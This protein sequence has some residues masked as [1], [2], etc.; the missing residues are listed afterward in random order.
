MSNEAQTYRISGFIRF[1]FLLG[2]ILFGAF[3]V[4]FILDNA[5]DVIDSC[6]PP[7]AL[8]FLG[9]FIWSLYTVRL[10]DRGISVTYFF[11]TVN[12]NW[13][14]ISDIHFKESGFIL[15]CNDGRRGMLINSQ[16]VGFIKIVE[17][18]KRRLPI[19]WNNKITYEFHASL[20]TFAVFAGIGLFGVAMLVWAISD[21]MDSSGNLLSD[22]ILAAIGLFCI[23]TPLIVPVKETFQEDYLI[24]T[25]LFWKKRIHASEIETMILEP[26][27]VENAFQ[28]PV[29]VKLKN[30]KSLVFNNLRE[31]TFI[32]ATSLR[33]WYEK[34]RNAKQRI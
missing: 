25:Y 10:T 4:L 13:N 5:S 27:M 15:S 9:A 14:E 31:G 7:I 29:H 17:E 18:V 3:S 12:L 16:V 22:A 24:I 6:F 20:S 32:F 33:H 21:L 2:F 28:Y 11:R 8:T 30:G 34:Y 19:I 23:G 26:K 1:I